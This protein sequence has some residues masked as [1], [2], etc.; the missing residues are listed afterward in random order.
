MQA[1]G[2]SRN[3]SKPDVNEY[4]LFILAII[5]VSSGLGEF[6]ITPYI[7]WVTAQEADERTLVT[8]PSRT[9]GTVA[10]GPMACFS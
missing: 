6:Y 5:G 10:H 2:G 1:G 4:A 8:L 7:A 3:I 9:L